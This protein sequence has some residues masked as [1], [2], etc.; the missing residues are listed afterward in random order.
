[1]NILIIGSGGREHTFAWKIKQSSLAKNIFVAP[2]N[3]GT[4]KIANNIDIDVCDFEGQKKFCLENNIDIVVVGPEVPLVE[5]IYDYFKNDEA[6]KHI[7]VIGPSKKGAQLEGSKSFAK[8]FMQRHH[9][10]TAAFNEFTSD[11][12]AQG[13]LF[14]EQNKAPFVLK[15]DGLA[16]GKGVV[17]T[18]D[19]ME[20]KATLIEMITAAKFGE[21]G[22][23]VIIEEF[24]KGIEFSVFVLTDGENYVILPEAKDYK[25]IG[26]GDKGLNTGGMGAVSPVPFVTDELMQKV[27]QKVVEPTVKGLKEEN[28]TYKGFIYVGLILVENEP[29]VIEYNCRMGDPETEIVLPRLE[30]DL[31]ELFNAVKHRNL[32]K[33]EIKH[34]KKHGATV[35]LAS[36]GYPESYEKGK[37]ISLPKAKEDVMVFHAGTKEQNGKLLTNGGRVI[38]VSALGES[39]KNALSKA[40]A[41]AN[42]IEFDKKYYRK[43]IGWEF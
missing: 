12:L 24:L 14:I 4:K 42:E 31:V 16:A 21:A 18:E 2:D 32:D 5:G 17:I 30:N 9:I 7:N 20:A 35:I 28:I 26:E 1:M 29:Y 13:F 43:D 36:G 27:I 19:K 33:V 37:E 8:Y 15:A 6:S 41:V 3:G 34:S 25:R 23:K 40:N 38:A 22:S 10:P 39:L 11:N